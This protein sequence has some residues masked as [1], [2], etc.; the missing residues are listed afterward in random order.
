M[1]FNAAT[2]IVSIKISQE[3]VGAK[4]LQN[5]GTMGMYGVE[6][7]KRRFASCDR[8]SNVINMSRGYGLRVK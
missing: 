4:F 3:L 6:L 8:P 2:I 5:D 7:S 1:L